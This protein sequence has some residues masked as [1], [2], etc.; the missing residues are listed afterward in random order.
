M[1]F[2]EREASY[3]LALCCTIVF[4]FYTY[5]NLFPLGCSLKCSTLTFILFFSFLFVFAGEPYSQCLAKGL[6]LAFL[7]LLAAIM[8]NP[9]FSRL[10]NGCLV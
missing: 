4:R 6:S 3:F 2:E 9:W 7:V 5:F 10:W 8:S 1:K